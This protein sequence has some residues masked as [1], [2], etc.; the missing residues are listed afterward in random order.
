MRGIKK[1]F[2]SDIEN[3]FG[4][5]IEDESQVGDLLLS[6]YSSLFSST[7][8]MQLEPVLF[9]VEAKVIDAMN[10]ELLRPFEASEVQAALKQ[11]DSNMA[12]RPDGLSPSILQTVLE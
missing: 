12:L 2:I 6:Y 10:N 8:L 5:W 3:D 11:M 1:K 9:G 7:N 4:E